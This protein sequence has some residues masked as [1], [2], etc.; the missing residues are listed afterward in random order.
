MRPGGLGRGH[1]L[2]AVDAALVAQLGVDAVAL[3][4]GD[5]F[6][7][8]ALAGP[9]HGDDVDLPALPL[10]EA[11]VHAEDLGREER[12][13]VAARPRADLEQDVL[14][15]V[16]VL[17]DEQQRDLGVQRVAPR[18]QRA[19]LLVGHLPH[20]G[21]RLRA[22]HLL[23]L[24]QLARAWPCRRGSGPRWARSPATPW[25]ASGR[26]TGPGPRPGPTSAAS[27]SANRASMS[28]SFSNVI[29]SICVSRVQKEETP[30]AALRRRL[31]G[32]DRGPARA[33][34]GRPAPSS[35]RTCGCSAPR[36]RRSRSASA[37]R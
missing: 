26:R 33:G 31:P 9:G 15:V 13:L 1:A 35:S 24:G 30:A 21:V 27:T 22:G 18:L 7:D 36:G 10:R 12:G 11:R 37:C 28:L 4:H 17:G 6:L 29:E 23:D 19:H 2:H 5:D 25:P 34:P 3:D 16:R 8:A 32:W 20:L 14:L